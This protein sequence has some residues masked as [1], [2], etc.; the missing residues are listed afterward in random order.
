MV[1]KLDAVRSAPSRFV[2]SSSAPA[3]V[4]PCRMQFD[5]LAFVRS[6]PVRITPLRSE[7]DRSA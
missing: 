6:A 2:L 7:L 4:A 5:R 1:P 3:S